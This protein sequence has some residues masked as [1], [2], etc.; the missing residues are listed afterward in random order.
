MEHFGC[1]VKTKNNKLD[2]S[3]YA[4][5]TLTTRKNS[6][7]K[8]GMYSAG[9]R[10]IYSS[11]DEALSA[12]FKNEGD[13]IVEKYMTELDNYKKIVYDIKT[14]DK[15]AQGY[16]AFFINFKHMCCISDFLLNGWS[17]WKENKYLKE[18]I[19][20]KTKSLME[21]RDFKNEFIDKSGREFCEDFFKKIK[22]NFKKINKKSLDEAIQESELL[23]LQ[24]GENLIKKAIKKIYL[25]EVNESLY[26]VKEKLNEVS[27]YTIE[28]ML[29]SDFLKPEWMCSYNTYRWPS[30]WKENLL[31]ISLSRMK[32]II[33]EEKFPYHIDEVCEKLQK[34]ALYNFD[35]NMAF[36]EKLDRNEFNKEIE[37][38]LSVNPKFVEVK[39]LSKYE[40]DTGIYIM[41]IDEYKRIYVGQTSKSIKKRIQ[42]HWCATKTLDRLIFGGID[43]SILSIDSFRHLDTTRIF[44]CT[45][46]NEDDLDSEEF[47]LTENA[48]SPEFLTNRIDGGGHSFLEAIIGRKSIDL[49]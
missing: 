22:T 5:I 30:S 9:K 13:S 19:Y 36:Y 31:D 6:F 37:H 33:Q 11:M 16:H 24:W 39:D 26:E 10:G 20:E 35:L 23:S 32:K 8:L 44:V 38:F 42:A 25:N 14:D 40:N 12:F 48:F 3:N 34:D 28:D 4:P 49:L 15:R 29:E 27:L 46:I 21:E 1:K 43:K 18:S 7:G 41:V 45:D 47:N 2:R 17:Y